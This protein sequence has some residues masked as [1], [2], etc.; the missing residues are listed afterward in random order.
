MRAA[1]AIQASMGMGPPSGGGAGFQGRAMQVDPMKPVL[2]APGSMLLKLIYDEPLSTSAFKF[3]LRRHTKATGWA[4]ASRQG[5]TLVH[6]SAQ[7]E[8]FLTQNTPY[9]P[10]I[11]PLYTP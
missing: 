6:F 7:P 1:A 10:P 5:L 8:P 2:K 9:T 11:H 3:N 4:R